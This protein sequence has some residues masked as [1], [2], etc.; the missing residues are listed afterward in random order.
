VRTGP[1]PAALL[2]AADLEHHRLAR[3]DHGGAGRYT[4]LLAAFEQLAFQHERRPPAGVGDDEL[5]DESMAGALLHDQLGGRDVVP[6][7]GH[8]VAAPDREDSEGAAGER[9]AQVQ[10][11]VQFK[12]LHELHLLWGRG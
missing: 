7:A 11:K 6:A 12:E 10:I 8:G 9:A 1:G 4:V 3:R 2:D 5:S